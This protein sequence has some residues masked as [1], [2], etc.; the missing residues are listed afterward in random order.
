MWLR[1]ARGCDI[2]FASAACSLGSVILLDS[3][4]LGMALNT[5]QFFLAG[6]SLRE[7]LWKPAQLS[8]AGRRGLTSWFWELCLR[9]PKTGPGDNVYDGVC[10]GGGE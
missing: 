4:A 5:T 8:L 3:L 9:L 1:R 7:A 10:G 2:A 6:G